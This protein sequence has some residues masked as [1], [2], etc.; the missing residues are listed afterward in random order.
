MDETKQ[1]PQKFKLFRV[2][3]ISRLLPNVRGEKYRFKRISANS[4]LSPI[5]GEGNTKRCSSGSYKPVDSRTDKRLEE[6]Q[7]RAQTAASIYRE[8]K[9]ENQIDTHGIL[10]GIQLKTS[11]LP[12][13]DEFTHNSCPNEDNRVKRKI[14][15]HIPTETSPR[16]TTCPANTHGYSDPKLWSRDLLITST[17]LKKP[18]SSKEVILNKPKC[19]KEEISNKPKRSKQEALDKHMNSKEETVN[20]T[21]IGAEVVAS[22]NIPR[23]SYSERKV[24]NNKVHWTETVVAEERTRSA[25]PFIRQFHGGVSNLGRPECKPPKFLKSRANTFSFD[26]T[27]SKINEKDEE[28]PNRRAVLR[29]LL[30]KNSPAMKHWSGCPFNCKDCFKACLVSEDYYIKLKEQRSS[31]KQSK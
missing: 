14:N 7:I 28:I 24:P 2:F 4:W 22:T 9:I 31:R 25:P 29:S 16:P 6:R 21:K 3:R 27:V 26:C 19:P 18:K 12:K 17:S 23:S 8:R 30:Q 5:G 1:V 15:L 13:N 10:K 11:A 20:K